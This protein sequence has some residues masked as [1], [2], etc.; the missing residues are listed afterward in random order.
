ML[1]V[2][3]A[4]QLAGLQHLLQQFL[5]R[6]AL[7]GQLD[8]RL[9]TRAVG[10]CQPCAVLQ[11]GPCNAAACYVQLCQCVQ[12]GVFPHQLGHAV[13]RAVRIG[14]AQCVKPIGD[15]RAGHGFHVV[16]QLLQLCFAPRGIGG[17]GQVLVQAQC[18][19]L[20]LDVLGV[21]VLERAT[22]CAAPG[23]QQISQLL[24]CRLGTC[25][26]QW[27]RQVRNSGGIA[28]PFGNHGFTHIGHGVQVQMRHIANQGI[29]PV[30]V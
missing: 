12:D 18:H 20:L 7:L 19:R 15:V 2:Q 16:G 17:Q 25:S 8:Q 14:R 29:G 1:P 10:L 23:Q 4:L 21:L 3:R 5:C 26:T 9:H 22:V 24:M 13:Q 27:R 30:V 11:L 6:L 28:A